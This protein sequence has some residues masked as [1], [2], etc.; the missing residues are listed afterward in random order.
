[1]LKAAKVIRKN[2]NTD[3]IRAKLRQKSRNSWKKIIKKIAMKI[4]GNAQPQLRN[5][6]CHCAAGAARFQENYRP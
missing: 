6:Q 5:R 1:M 3:K 2:K 4:P